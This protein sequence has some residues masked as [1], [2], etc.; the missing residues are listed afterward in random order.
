M[1]ASGEILSGAIL[2][3]LLK[4]HP[5]VRPAAG[6]RD[7][8]AAALTLGARRHGLPRDF[9]STVR[10]FRR[11]V[12]DAYALDRTAREL[13]FFEIEVYNPMTSAKLQAYGRLQT[14]MAAFGVDFQVLVVNKYGH[15]NRVDLLPYYAA[16]LRAA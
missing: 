9:V 6:W 14:D 15:V 12:P 1:A 7:A 16:S 2:A 10:A 13:H 11:F 4:Q 5:E 8:A 3:A